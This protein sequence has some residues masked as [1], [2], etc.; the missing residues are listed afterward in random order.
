LL[1]PSARL[2]VEWYG[3]QC[4]P[5]FSDGTFALDLDPLALLARLATTVP[6]PRFHTIRYA[7]VLAA[8]SKWRARVVPPPPQYDDNNDQGC[9]TCDAKDRPPTHRSGYR[10]WRELLMRS[11]KIDI[12]RCDHCGAR[13]KLRALVMT[14]AAIQRYLAWLGEPTEPPT[15]APAR[16]PPFFKSRLIRRRLAEPTQAEMF[17]A[18]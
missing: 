2:I 14:S 4:T 9:T 18:H 13:M 1:A 7:G 5:R 17:D 15:L 8:A 11:F 12:E 3:T 6:P 16:A 10:P